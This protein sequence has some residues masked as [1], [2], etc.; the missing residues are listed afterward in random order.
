[1][2]EGR[3][4]YKLREGVTFLNHGSFGKCPL[5]VLQKQQELRDEMEEEP[6]DFLARKIYR[7]LPEA[8]AA[9]AEFIGAPPHSVVFFRN[10]TSALNAAVRAV[11]PGLLL[12]PDDEVLATDH[13]YGACDRL[14]VWALEQSGRGAAQYRRV[15]FAGLR[16]DPACTPEALAD[17]FCAHFS[18]R[19]RLVFLSH[20]TSVTALVL[21]VALICARARDRGIVTI[22]DG[23]HA[24]GQL[25]LDVTAIGADFYAGNCHKWLQSPKGCGFLYAAPHRQVRLFFAEVV[26]HSQN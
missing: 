7:L 13:E 12:A 16:D 6:V 18:P 19:T 25:E 10:V 15:A 2:E 5:E 26:I 1:M 24:L 23:A 22:V 20:I 3:S 21:P 9:L 17:E 4:L 11:L 14:F 8:T